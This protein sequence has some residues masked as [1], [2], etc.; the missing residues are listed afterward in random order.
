ME[1]KEY[2]LYIAVA[3]YIKRGICTEVK[4]EQI[5]LSSE[6]DEDLKAVKQKF[7]TWL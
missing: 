3:N 1:G 7:Y 2:T 6:S 4:N 5:I